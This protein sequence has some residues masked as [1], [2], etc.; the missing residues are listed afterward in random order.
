MTR[1]KWAKNEAVAQSNGRVHVTACGL[2][3]C[4]RAGSRVVRVLAGSRAGIRRRPRL[5]ALPGRLCAHLLLLVIHFVSLLQLS[6]LDCLR[7]LGWLCWMQCSN[8]QNQP[9]GGQIWRGNRID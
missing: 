7:T 6:S 5:A 1:C 2:I 3:E 4:R 8:M 9:A